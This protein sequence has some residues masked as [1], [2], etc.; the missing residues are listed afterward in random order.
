MKKLMI[1]AASVLLLASCG[2]EQWSGF[3]YPNKYNFTERRAVGPFNS[4][5]E[6]QAAAKAEISKLETPD[7]AEY[8][9]GLNCEDIYGGNGP[10][11][12]KE[13]RK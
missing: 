7:N 4:F 2:D 8:E 9:C 11:V 1:A 12:C 6:C 5:E 13:T 10:Q 3:I